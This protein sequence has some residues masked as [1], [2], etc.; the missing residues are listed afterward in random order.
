MAKREPEVEVVTM[1]DGRAV[2][3]TGKT[4]LRKTVDIGADGTVTLHMDF[5]NGEA[6]HIALPESLI[7]KAAG[8]GLSQKFG[9]EISS[10]DDIEDAVEAID[11]LAERVAKGDW[12]VGATGGSGMAGASILAKALVEVT[13][14]T[15]SVV[16]EYLG[17]LDNK[18]KG[19]LRKDPKVR[20]VIE[21]LEAEKAERAA[22]RGKAAPTVDTAAILA[23]LTAPA[24]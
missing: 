21:R 8:H 15:V 16:R 18:T 17:K 19:E 14:Q 22:K 2:E 9:D 12:N 4:R 10:V 20:P 3:F 7:L 23:G 6:R 13:G 5:R 11:T 24:A 1:L